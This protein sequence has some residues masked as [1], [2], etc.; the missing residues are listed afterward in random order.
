MRV[1]ISGGGTGGHLF[2]A[3]AIAQ[4]LSRKDPEGQV[5]YL[6]SK[7]GLE[8]QVIPRYGIPFQAIPAAGLYTDAVWRNLRLPYIMPWAYVLAS[9]AIRRFRPDAVV[10]TGGYVT[11]PVILAAAR[12]GLPIVLLEQNLEPG[13]AT[14]LLARFARAVATAY[15]ESAGYLDGRAVLTGTPVRQDFQVRKPDFPDRPR[16]LLVLGGSQGA[17]RINQAVAEALP[18]LLARPDVSVAHQTGP[19]HLAT[20]ETARASLPESQRGRY[21]PFAFTEDLAT[22]LRASDLVLARAGA[23]TLSETSAVGVPM[24]LVPGDFAGGHQRLNA[25]PFETAGAAVVI[26][27]QECDGPRLLRELAG[28]LDHPERYRRMVGAMAQLGRPNAADDV[29]DLVRGVA[30]D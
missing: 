10:G 8:A 29:A 23:S 19:R 28:I 21:H 12:R 2:P 17:L 15:Q 16:R 3:I 20:M 9:R 11:V 7:T 25:R 14:R 26:A 6:G 4:A 27:N 5:L 1:L 18:Q 13:R 22:A 24:I 30:R